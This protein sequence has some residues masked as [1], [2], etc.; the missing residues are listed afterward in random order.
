MFPGLWSGQEVMFSV[1]RD[2]SALRASEEKFARVFRN[3]PALMAVSTIDEGRYLE[4][5]ETFLETLGYARSEVIGAT[6]RDLKAFAD[7][8]QR[9]AMRKAVLEG[10]SVRNYEVAVRRKDGQIRNGLFSAEMIEIQNERC[11]LLVLI[12]KAVDSTREAVGIT[13]PKGVRYYQ[14]PAFTSLFGYS[15]EELGAPFGPTIIYDDADVAREVFG[16]VMHG[17][18]WKGETIMVAKDGRRFPAV[19]RADAIRDDSSAYTRI[20]ASEG[21]ARRSGSSCWTRPNAMRGP[22]RNCS[23]RSITG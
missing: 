7:P 4:V 19:V 17:R 18:S 13:D 5:N 14:N 20:S 23:P 10:G 21:A 2:V 6:F 15:P 11:L 12:R 22:R 3:N 16:E 9:D 1:S 8:G